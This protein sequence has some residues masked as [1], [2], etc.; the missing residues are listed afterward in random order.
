MNL[1]L[2]IAISIVLLQT[3]GVNAQG[4]KSGVKKC[5]TDYK[6]AILEGRGSDALNCVDSTTVLYYSH[7]LELTRSGDSTKVT[8]LPIID[9]MTVM[10]LRH[11]ATVEEI[12]SFDG[13]KLF[14]YAIEKGMVGKSSVM[15]L[16]LGDIA[17]EENSAQGQAVVNGQAVPLY[18]RFKKE[19]SI[20]KM[21]LTSIFPAT[22]EAF[23]K[24]IEQSGMSENEF[25]LT[26]LE[27]LTGKT[28]SPGIWKPVSSQ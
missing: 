9:K 17:M 23:K 16:E 27:N 10:S 25:L 3:T 24:V 8:A 7:I 6:Q 2:R 12:L 14:V 22:A 21:D 26:L 1:Y 5:F 15:N 4:K 13:K 18:F 28:P 11:R 19:N 20:W